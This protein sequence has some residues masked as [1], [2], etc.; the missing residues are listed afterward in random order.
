VADFQRDYGDHRLDNVA[1]R[2]EIVF[3]GLQRSLGCWKMSFRDEMELNIVKAK[4][5]KKPLVRD[6]VASFL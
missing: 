5:T 4:P 1:H 3:D 6:W 2:Y